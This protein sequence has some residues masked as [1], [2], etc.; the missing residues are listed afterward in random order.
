M[1]SCLSPA[2]RAQG[3]GLSWDPGSLTCSTC[4]GVALQVMESKPEFSSRV[5][6]RPQHSDGSA[7]ECLLGCGSRLALYWPLPGRVARL[8]GS[9]LGSGSSGSVLAHQGHDAGWWPRLG[10]ERMLQQLSS[11]GPLGRVTH[12]QAIQEAFQRR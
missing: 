2:D 7:L 8:F 9:G 5:L 6:R 1:G 11:S 10:E 4:P 3:R 12:Q